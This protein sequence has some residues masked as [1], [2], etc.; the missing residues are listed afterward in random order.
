ME[1]CNSQPIRGLQVTKKKK[2]SPVQ[3]YDENTYLGLYFIEGRKAIME[4]LYL[5]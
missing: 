5:L 4:G 3:F 2:F 1:D